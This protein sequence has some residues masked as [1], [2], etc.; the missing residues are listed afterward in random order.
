M[1]VLVYIEIKICRFDVKEKLN[2]IEIENKLLN[3]KEW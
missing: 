3:F 1:E 2:R